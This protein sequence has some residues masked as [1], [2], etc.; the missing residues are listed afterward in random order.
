ASSLLRTHPPPTATRPAP[1]GV[2]VEVTPSS[3]GLPVFRSISLSC[4]PSRLPR[5]DCL[6]S[7]ARP[8]QPAPAFP[9]IR[10]GRLPH[11]PF[12]GLLGVHSRYG[13]HA[14]LAASCDP[15]S[16]ECFSAI[17]YLLSPL[18]LLPAGATSCRVGLSPT[19]AR[20]LFTAHRVV[21]MNGRFAIT[22]NSR[23]FRPD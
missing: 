19:G 16:S 12:R 21:R 17:R 10:S 20:R 7:V 3:R 15:S 14:C 13:L 11:Y 6:D 22:P 2:S 5:R 9:A 18:R 1:R 4:R 8:V 23:T